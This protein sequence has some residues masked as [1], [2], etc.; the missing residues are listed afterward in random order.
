MRRASAAQAR[1]CPCLYFRRPCDRSACRRGDLQSRP[2]T[3]V[4]RSLP[5]RTTSSTLARAAGDDRYGRIS[6]ARPDRAPTAAFAGAKRASAERTSRRLVCRPQQQCRG[7]FSKRSLGCVS[8][9]QKVRTRTIGATLADPGMLLDEGRSTRFGTTS[10]PAAIIHR[11]RNSRRSSRGHD[12]RS[13]RTCL[14]LRR[15]SR[16]RAE[17]SAAWFPRG[18]TVA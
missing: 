18:R 7:G 6:T 17:T 16:P 12:A 14:V 1:A 8:S 15:S 10:S 3:A 2:C 13:T 5:R 4:R 11:D 9:D